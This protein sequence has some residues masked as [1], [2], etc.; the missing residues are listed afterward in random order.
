[1]C[2]CVCVHL[3]ACVCMRASVCVC[4]CVRAS[5]CVCML[6]FVFVCECAYV[7]LLCVCGINSCLSSHLCI[8][9]HLN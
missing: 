6:L 8:I 1:M 2:V 7:K 9:I 4:V 3:F 5:V